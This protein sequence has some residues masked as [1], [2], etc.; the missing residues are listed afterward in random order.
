[1]Y[2][3]PLGIWMAYWE[4]TQ[5]MRCFLAPKKR[6]PN[7]IKPVFE[8]MFAEFAKPGVSVAR[9]QRSIEGEYASG[10]DQGPPLLI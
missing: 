5:R 4:T 8:R 3:S 7:A 10:G 2:A 9:K 1:M 6:G